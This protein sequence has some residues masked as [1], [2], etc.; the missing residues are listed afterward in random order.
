MHLLKTPSGE[1]IQA[2]DNRLSAARVA[3][4]ARPMEALGAWS[5]EHGP[6]PFPSP[7]ARAIFD[8]YE[9]SYPPGSFSIGSLFTGVFF[10]D[11][12]VWPIDV[13]F[14]TGTFRITIK[15]MVANMTQMIGDRLNKD[16]QALT[17]LTA[18]GADSLDYG[19]GI[20][21]LRNTPLGSPLANDMLISGHTELQGAVHVLLSG[22]ANEKAAE[23]ATL[24]VEMFFK[25]YLAHH[26]G[27]DEDGAKTMRHDL[28]KGLRQ[29]LTHNSS[30]DLRMLHGKLRNLPEVGGRYKP[31]S[32]S[33]KEI[34]YAY[35]LAQFAGTCV[36]RSMTNRDC[37]LSLPQE[38]S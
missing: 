22:Q 7:E 5:M 27:L 19:Y 14:A 11:E 8:W 1:W 33:L 18:L 6:T 4:R 23:S 32:M 12:A 13:P 38:P 20:D 25:S 10:F 35:S 16:S 34:W 30:C 17:T 26:A 9:K 31:R 2:T 15:K 28:K 3:V 29:C 21:D 36:V 37:R 24:A